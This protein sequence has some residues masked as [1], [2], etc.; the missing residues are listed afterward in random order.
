MRLQFSG[1]LI[2]CIIV[3]NLGPDK[4]QSAPPTPGDLA[5]DD[6]VPLGCATCRLA[7]LPFRAG[8]LTASQQT[9][10]A[11]TYPGLKAEV[12]WDR[13]ETLPLAGRK[14]MNTTYLTTHRLC[15]IL[16]SIPYHW[17]RVSG[18]A[19]ACFGPD[20]ALQCQGGPIAVAVPATFACHHR[21]LSAATGAFRRLPG[22]PD[23]LRK[24]EKGVFSWLRS[25][26]SPSERV[27]LLQLSLGP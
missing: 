4:S 10:A 8:R 27:S 22:V 1:R 2:V 23:E 14:Q 19:A 15:G 12:W 18:L 24:Q 20:P 6:A 11:V 13:L 16:E 21:P 7:T 17:L 26:M 5:L 9:G 25:Q 3:V